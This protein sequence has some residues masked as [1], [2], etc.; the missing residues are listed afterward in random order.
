M[1]D[2]AYSYTHTQDDADTTWNVAHNLGIAT[3][4]VQVY[5]VYEGVAQRIQ[6]VSV[7]SVDGNNITITFSAALAGYAILK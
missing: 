2:F 5:V 6:P 7:V 3:P 1:T 4:V